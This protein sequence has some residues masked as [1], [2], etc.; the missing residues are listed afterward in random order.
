MSYRVILNERA[1]DQLEAAYLWWFE[2]RSPKQA[3]RWYNVFLDSLDGL[4]E[5]P[6]RFG[7]AHENPRF[8]YSVREMLFGLGK[9]TT[10]RALCTIRTNA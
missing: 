4:R 9:S 5:T 10:H 2:H 8:P 1:E 3:T 6:D 7:V